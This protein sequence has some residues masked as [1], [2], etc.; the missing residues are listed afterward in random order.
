MTKRILSVLLALLLAL[1]AV[2]ALAEVQPKAAGTVAINAKNFPDKTF[3][4]ALKKICDKNGDGKLSAAEIKAVK[5][6][7][8]NPD[9]IAVSEWGDDFWW[10]DDLYDSFKSGATATLTATCGGKTASVKVTLK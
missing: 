3:R 8:S 1:S 2:S 5:Y 9:V 6:T 7:T 10:N 4:K